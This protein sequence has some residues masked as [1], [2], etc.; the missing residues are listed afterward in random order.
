MIK[1]IVCL[2]KY[3]ELISEKRK[4]QNNNYNSMLSEFKKM[5]SHEN[6]HRGQIKTVWMTV[7]PYLH[8]INN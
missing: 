5:K 3:F 8:P 6:S 1:S 4:K 2:N 7:T